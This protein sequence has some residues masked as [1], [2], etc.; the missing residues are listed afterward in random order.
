MR[1]L[2]ANATTR[3]SLLAVAQNAQRGIGCTTMNTKNS[4]IVLT[5][6]KTAMTWEYATIASQSSEYAKNVQKIPTAH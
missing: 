4:G 1:A 3:T 6:V 5:A 2:I